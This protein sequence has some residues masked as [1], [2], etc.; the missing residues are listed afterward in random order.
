[1]PQHCGFHSAQEG[2]AG[3]SV[4]VFP[5]DVPVRVQVSQLPEPTLSE[6]ALITNMVLIWMKGQVHTLREDRQ[7]HLAFLTTR[8]EV[9]LLRSTLPSVNLGRVAAGMAFTSGILPPLSLF[10]SSAGSVQSG[11]SI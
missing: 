6:G 8:T 3:G 1:L 2:F 5:Q 10:G 11:G 7:G 4:P 9:M